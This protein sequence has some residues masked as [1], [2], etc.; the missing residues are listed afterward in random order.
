MHRIQ[1]NSGK[2]SNS[3]RVYNDQQ[4]FSTSSDNDHLLKPPLDFSGTESTNL[5]NVQ[6]QLIDTHKLNYVDL[7]AHSSPSVIRFTG[8]I[9]ENL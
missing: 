4:R 1:S 7:I 2:P 6:P 8:S 9:S 5:G 3:Y